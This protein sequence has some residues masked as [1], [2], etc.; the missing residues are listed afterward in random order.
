MP[1][2]ALGGVAEQEVK[3]PL[4]PQEADETGIVAQFGDLPWTLAEA[5]KV[6]ETTGGG[7]ITG[8]N[9]TPEA[10]QLA[11][12]VA[13]IVHIASHGYWHPVPDLSFVLLAP[14]PVSGKPMLFEQ[15]VIN[16]VTRAELITLSGCQTGLGSPHPDSYL[17]LANSFLVAGARCVLVSLWP[18][19][20]DATL[21][22]AE[23]F[24]R[25][26]RD[27]ASPAGALRTVQAEFGGMLSPWDYA[28]F[29]AIG[30]PF[31]D[32][33]VV[34]RAETASGPAF[35]GGDTMC[36]GAA[37]GELTDLTMFSDKVQAH[38]EA[39]FIDGSD[40]TVIRKS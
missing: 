39:W 17:T 23:S 33:A 15:Q 2:I 26:L 31:Y 35:C 18:V 34:D 25:H 38:D 12:R 20:D 32:M 14:S 22:F 1:A 7:C 29:A 11:M 27:G 21:A 36:T 30:N 8:D 37:R 3:V 13:A 9:A 10:L 40:I 4:L 5:R 6:A 19:R 16:L 28:G 24:Y